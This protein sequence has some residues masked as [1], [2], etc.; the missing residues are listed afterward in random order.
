MKTITGS[1]QNSDQRIGKSHFVCN[2]NE[3]G[4]IFRNHFALKR[5]LLVH[6]NR[7]QHPCKYC[8]KSFTL[9]Q[10]LKEHE[11]LHTNDLP[12][13]CG[14]SGCN[15][16]FRQAGKLS[17]HRRTHPEY[18]IKK[19]D[20]SLNNQTRI[21]K[22]KCT[23]FRKRKN[24]VESTLEKTSQKIFAFSYVTDTINSQELI[25]A[26]PLTLQKSKES[27]SLLPLLKD[28]ITKS[29]NML[30]PVN[31]AHDQR[32]IK[33]DESKESVIEDSKLMSLANFIQRISIMPILTCP[34]MDTQL[35]TSPQSGL[36]LI[37]LSNTYNH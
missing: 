33:I 36:N 19:Y 37:S 26:N 31:S 7:R 30:S 20:Y 1:A 29:T 4:R 12:Y 2:H 5:H 11:C 22:L 16:K 18:T 6:D 10:Y 21:K 3:C 25:S 13:V 34:W 24:I 17:L 8:D 28:T 15:M 14:I 35:S 9:K 27:V 23:S 32:S